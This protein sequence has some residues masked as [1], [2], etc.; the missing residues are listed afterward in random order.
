M[1]EQW[2]LILNQAI[3]EMT[4]KVIDTTIRKRLWLAML[5]SRG[6]IKLGVDGSYARKRPIDWKEPPILSLSHSTK[7]VYAPRDYLKWIELGWKGFY[8][9]DEMGIVEYYEIANSAHA[10]VSRYS[11]I[12]PKLLKGMKNFLGAQLYAN[13]NAT[14]HET[15]FDGIET[16]CGAGT[17]VVGD[18]VAVPD[19]HYQG[20]DTDLGQAGSWSDDLTTSPN[21]T[22]DTDWPE[23]SG[24]PEYCY[25]S[26]LL[27]NWSSSAWGTGAVTWESNCE[28][29]L[30]RTADW[31]RCTNSGEGEGSS[32]IAMLATGLMSGFKNTLRARNVLLSPLKEADDLGF[33][34][35]LNY[36]GIGVHAEVNT[37]ANTGYV[38]DMDDI[39]LS[40][41]T[42]DMIDQYGP[43]KES[44]MCWK[45][46]AMTLGNLELNLRRIAKLYNYAAA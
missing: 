39:T 45:W 8:A 44:D 19:G 9:T 29:V 3:P 27:V 42:K 30:S 23:G 25:R 4:Q 12:L 21:S 11:R 7:P 24:T 32:L 16:G 43:F 36:E 14:G 35:V 15:D 5:Q 37:P 10:I 33:P 31:I 17:C 18:L 41:L 1:A 40:F 34:E 28:R 22:I 6:R 20:L 26:P 46:F 2:E 38:V 13:S